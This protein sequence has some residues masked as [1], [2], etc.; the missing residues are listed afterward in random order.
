M[1]L[2]KI[3]IIQWNC[4]GLSSNFINLNILIKKIQPKIICLQETKIT[5]NKSIEIKNYK[6]YKYPAITTNTN[7]SGGVITYIHTKLLQS[8][9]KVNIQNHQI[10]AAK[11]TLDIPITICN[12]YT[13]PSNNITSTDLIKLI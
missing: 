1:N 8:P 4:R 2:D 11:V 6:Q 3:S 9:I 13:P 12:C 5:S 7:P 10:I